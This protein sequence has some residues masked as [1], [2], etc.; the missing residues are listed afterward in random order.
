MIQDNILVEPIAENR[1]AG[2]IL[3]V[4][5]SAYKEAPRKGKVVAISAQAK[6]I[7]PMRIGDVVLYD[8]PR[9]QR[10]IDNKEYAWLHAY[11]IYGIV[12]GDKAEEVQAISD[13][14]F[15]SW[16]FATTEYGKSGI[17][18]PVTHEKMH[19]TG[20]VIS[21][22]EGVYDVRPGDRIFFDQFSNPGKFQDGE[23][24]YAFI[25][26][27]PDAIAIIP[28]RAEVHSPEMVLA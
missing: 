4:E 17:L 10:V 27:H 13:N 26:E 12:L 22:G 20:S 23:K 1:F 16:D 3:L 2:K 21:V 25:R 8:M 24:R 7:G 28:E 18:R 6:K 5:T 15:L 14:I 19:Y 11:E 9:E